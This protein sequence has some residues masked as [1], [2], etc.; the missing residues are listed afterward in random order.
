MQAQCEN[1]ELKAQLSELNDQ[2]ARNEEAQASIEEQLSMEQQETEALQ[3]R[4]EKLSV[5]LEESRRQATAFDAVEAHSESV[6]ADDANDS[7]EEECSDDT[8]SM[9]ILNA[10]EVETDGSERDDLQQIK[11]VGAK[12]AQKL[13][14]LG[15]VNFRGLTELSSEDYERAQELIPSLKSRIDRDGWVEQARQLHQEK[16]NE[17]L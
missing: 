1:E 10:A 9:P 2:Q 14:M 13:N 7:G 16:Y 12:L 5:E 17:S 4:I 8:D 6:E 11:G 15:I 3:Q